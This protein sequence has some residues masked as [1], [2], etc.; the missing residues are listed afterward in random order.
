[1]KPSTNV[2]THKREPGSGDTIKG[3]PLKSTLKSGN[4]TTA[5]ENKGK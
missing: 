3:S 4:T 2:V 5:R 1:M